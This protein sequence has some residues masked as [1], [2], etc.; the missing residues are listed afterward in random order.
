MATDIEKVEQAATSNP[1]DLIHMDYLERM[2]YLP[3]SPSYSLGQQ[4]MGGGV[5]EFRTP[6][7]ETMM[8]GGPAPQYQPFFPGQSAPRSVGMMAPVAG[9]DAPQIAANFFNRPLAT[10]TQPGLTADEIY[11][12]ANAQGMTAGQLANLYT[13]ATPGA[14]YQDVLGNINKWL[15]QEGKT[16]GGAGGMFSTGGT[17]MDQVRSGMPT[18]AD[19]DLYRQQKETMATKSEQPSIEEVLPASSFMIPA[20]YINPQFGMQEWDWQ[21]QN[22]WDQAIRKA[23]GK[24]KIM[25]MTPIMDSSGRLVYVVTPETEK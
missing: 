9:A 13:Q 8:G 4:V 18:Q 2:G 3:G 11:A 5:P 24:E 16:L 6:S 19:V 22:N 15:G 1:L 23:G 25:G 14:D 7:Y 17:F 21:Q 12:A 10:E 20:E